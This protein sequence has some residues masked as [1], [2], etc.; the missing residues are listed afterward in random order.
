MKKILAVLG[1]CLPLAFGQSGTVTTGGQPIPG[2]TVKATQGERVLTTV[3]DDDGTFQFQNMAPGAWTVEADMFGFEHMRKDTQIAATPTKIDLTLQLQARVEIAP[4]APAGGARGGGRG[5]QGAGGGRGGQGQGNAQQPDLVAEAPPEIVQIAPDS[6]NEAL[7]V[8]GTVSTGLQ[9]NNNDFRGGDFGP[10]GFPGGP[11]GDFGQGGPGGPGGGDQGPRN[12]AGGR[13]GRGGGGDFAGGGGGFPGGGFPGG[14]GRGGGGGGGGGG[15]GGGGGGRGGRGQQGQARGLIGNR[16]R[17]GANQIRV[18]VFDTLSDSAFNAKTYSLN[19]QTVTKPQAMTNRYGLNVGGPAIIPHLFDLSNKLNFTVNYNGTIAKQSFS[20]FST[21]PTQAERGGDLSSVTNQLYDPLS[22]GKTP[23]LNNQIPLNRISPIA[24]ALLDPK[25]IPLPVN[26]GLVQNYQ[27]VSSQ[28]N[29]SQQVSVR[30]QYTVRPKDRL[31]IQWQYQNRHSTTAQALG[32]LDTSSGDGQNEQVQWTH[33]FSSRL[34]NSLSGTFNRN[35]TVGTPFFQTLG[36][37]IASQLGIAGPSGN[38][39]NFGPPTLQFTSYTGLNDGYPTKNAVQTAGFTDTLSVRRGKHNLQ[40]GGGFTRNDTNL[41]NDSNG[42][43]TFQFTGSQTAQLDASGFAVRNTGSDLA[44]FLLGLPASNSVRYQSTSEYLRGLSYRAFAQDDY[45]LASTLSLTL[46][47]SYDYQS[48]ISEKYGHLANLD[49]AP[50]FSGA[51]VVTPTI[52]GAYGGVYPSALVN[53][54][55]NNFSPRLGA[56]WRAMKRGNL[57]IRPSWGIYFNNGVYNNL[58]NQMAAQPPYVL[59]SGTIQTASNNILT[60]ANGLL[61]TTPGKSIVNT[62]GVDR[63]YRDAYV[64]TWALGIQRDMPNQLVLQI[65]YTGTKGTALDVR[66]DPNQ[67]AP[68]LASNAL[69]RAP[70][71]YAA[72]FTY[73]LPVGNSVLHQ[74]QIQLNRRMRN[75]LSFSASYTL[76]KSIDDTGNGTVLNPLDISAERALSN[77]DHRHN[78]SFQWLFQSPVDGRKGFLANKGPLTKALKDWTFQS[79]S[80]F[81]TGAPL[82]ATVLGDIAGI[83]TTNGQRAEVTGQALSSGSGYFNLGAFAIPASGTF[84]NAGRNTITGPS[85][86][87]MNLNMSR[88]INLKERKSLEIQINS[89]NILNHPNVTSFGT[90]V[91]SLNYGIPTAVGGMRTIQGTIRFRM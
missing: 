65:N 36:T 23:F 44:D 26:P 77:S 59:S 43:G 20:P 9:T 85:Q 71:A 21:V 24:L 82:T 40:F 38:P 91:G 47:V 31:S 50:G 66:L 67:A 84:G 64:Q 75:N 15:R 28:P 14:G 46:G 25:F 52:P 53:G 22:G 70:I 69:A 1:V 57:L 60:L 88:T 33:N 29:N 87:T 12:Q 18:Q 4:A 35:N 7:L 48:P 5:G 79:Q 86:F 89:T 42:R 2:V 3:T 16:S 80:Q 17:Q 54:D 90:T 76:A 8:Q 49:L 78:V 11:G 41:F 13:G 32:F 61:Q 37:N 81:Q 62:F 74:G 45:R 19:G 73:D 51:S 63:N 72:P 39:A 30:L 58:A 10:G 55:H 27:F 56:A 83:G 6:T 68:G 34:F